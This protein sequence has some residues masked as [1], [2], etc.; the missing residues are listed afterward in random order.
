MSTQ[1]WADRCARRALDA[2]LNPPEPHWMPG[3]VARKNVSVIP[4]AHV[5]EIEG[6]HGILMF[7]NPH[8]SGEDFV[9]R[10]LL[11]AVNTLRWKIAAEPLVDVQ[12]EDDV[13]RG[14][15]AFAVSRLNGV[16][17]R[18]L[19]DHLST[20]YADA[21]VPD[22]WLSIDDN[23]YFINTDMVQKQFVCPV[24]RLDVGSKAYAGPYSL[25]TKKGES[26]EREES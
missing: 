15:D 23:C 5:T 3:K 19:V 24:L 14:I 7:F 21:R 1:E 10:V 22:E 17:L 25:A 9:E 2:L 12:W 8:E 26:D 16:S 4:A 20:V 13:P 6:Q 18:F 11:P